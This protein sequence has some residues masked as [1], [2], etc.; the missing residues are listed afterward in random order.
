MFNGCRIWG[1]SRLVGITVEISF[2]LGKRWGLA[3]H[4]RTT[5]EEH[6]SNTQIHLKNTSLPCIFSLCQEVVPVQFDGFVEVP[7]LRPEA[8]HYEQRRASPHCIVPNEDG[9]V[10]PVS[11]RP[12][13]PIIG[14]F[15]LRSACGH[16]TSQ[17]S[18]KYTVP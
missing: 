8:L 3:P 15:E 2:R 1:E 12:V 5:C 16:S 4:T 9:Q 6:R 18:V 11:F 17:S 14:C 10:G 13:P 7:V